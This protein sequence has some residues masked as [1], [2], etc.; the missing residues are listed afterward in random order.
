MFGLELWFVLAIASA[1]AGGISSF[2]Y[3][4]AAKEKVDIVL[5][6][7]FGALISSVWLLIVIVLFSDFSNFWHP[8]LIF[9]GLTAVTYLITNVMK[10]KSLENID[11]T[12]FFPLYK[13]F[14]PGLVIILGITFFGETFTSTEWTGLV[15]SLFIPLLLIS[16]SEDGRQEN[17]KLG[18]VW[19]AVAVVMGAISAGFW[20]HGAD[21]AP[22]TWMYI[23]VGEL[24][25]IPFAFLTL[26][27]KHRKNLFEKIVEVKQTKFLKILVVYSTM[28]VIAASVFIFA[29]TLGGPLGI[30]YTINSLYIL[31]PII[32]AI[33]FYNEH[34]NMRKAVA[35]I[36]SVLALALLG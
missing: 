27:R 25:M 5:L 19:L 14:G 2:L 1:F 4:V 21:I 15:L 17:L 20:K 22:N 29:F 7:F 9:A 8:M 16:K 36:L 31:I 18:L 24:F 34:W 35:I 26:Y 30:V 6:S 10:V 32:L 23:L 33:I 28:N 3:K 13:V 12:I 11:A